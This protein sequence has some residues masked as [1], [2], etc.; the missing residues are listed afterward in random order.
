MGL[1]VGQN[2][3]E[4]AGGDAAAALLIDLVHQLKNLLV[5]LAGEG[6]DEENGCIGHEGEVTVDVL[7]HALH[8]VGLFFNEVPLVDHHDAG[9]AR[10][11]G[12]TGDLGV[13]LGDALTGIHHDD[14]DIRTLNGH[15]GTHDGELL[16]AVVHLGLAADAGG[17]YEN[18]LAEFVVHSGIHA[19]TGGAGH[20]GHDHTLFTQNEV[21]E[22]G[23]AH[24]GLADHGHTDALLV[25]VVG[26]LVGEVLKAGVQQLV[27]A[28]AVDGGEGDGIAQTQRIELI[29]VGVH[30]AGGVHLVDAEHHG[31]AGA[32][33]HGGHFLVGGGDAGADLGD[34]NDDI[35]G[36]DG[37]HGLLTHEHEDLVVGTRLDAAGVHDVKDT[38]PPLALGI[39]PVAG[40]AGG[41]LHDGELLPAEAVEEQGLA[42]VGPSHNGYQR[43]C[44][45]IHTSFPA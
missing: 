26:I 17:V 45:V 18:V 16:N 31:L 10:F 23:L 14:A 28:V 44:H 11:V 12:E 9:L 38:A 39:K 30:M 37:Q 33:Q 34:E 35:G 5:T 24:V 13:L 32:L 19:V 27:G 42:H 21:D 20:V 15:L 1:G 22:G 4:K 6:G 29:D 7:L 8:G 40:D 41:I 36:V 25:L 2:V 3:V 43:F